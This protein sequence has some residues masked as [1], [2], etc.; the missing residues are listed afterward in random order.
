[1]LGILNS[2]YQEPPC[3]TVEQRGKAAVIGGPV[4]HRLTD[5]GSISP[6][7]TYVLT[8]TWGCSA[9]LLPHARARRKALGRSVKRARVDDWLPPR[10]LCSG[11]QSPRTGVMGLGVPY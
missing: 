10:Q 11:R 3:Q 9:R 1:M 4:E 2:I 5:D 6:P 8:D 7:P